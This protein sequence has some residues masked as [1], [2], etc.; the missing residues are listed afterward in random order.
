MLIQL[1]KVSSRAWKSMRLFQET[2]KAKIGAQLP[3]VA[4]ANGLLLPDRKLAGFE[5][6]RAS[7]LLLVGGAL[8]IAGGV[9]FLSSEGANS[10]RAEEAFLSGNGSGSSRTSPIVWL[11]D[12]QERLGRSIFVTRRLAGATWIEGLAIRGENASHQTLTGLQAAIKTESGEEIKLAV[13]AEGS[14]GKGVDAQDVPPG[15]KFLLKSAVNPGGTQAGM[16]ADEFL[17]KYGGMIFRVSYTVAGVETTLI[18]Y[19]STSRVR[20][21][22][23]NLN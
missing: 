10:S 9:V 21:R 1:A 23:A 22:L 4:G 20:A 14:Q 7:A 17:S 13:D 6:S 19:F 11:H 18:E 12:G 15:S 16:P 3:K 2:G 8:S 5:L